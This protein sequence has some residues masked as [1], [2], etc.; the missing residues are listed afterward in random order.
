MLPQKDRIK[1]QFMKELELLSKKYE[2]MLQ[3]EDSTYTNKVSSLE[4]NL[5]KVE[6]NRRL[7]EVF[8]LK[9]SMDSSPTTTTGLYYQ[10]VLV[11]RWCPVY[12]IMSNSCQKL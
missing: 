3:E 2:A 4:V 10:T 8:R 9:N 5:K 11:C 6:I 1:A 12:L 7:A